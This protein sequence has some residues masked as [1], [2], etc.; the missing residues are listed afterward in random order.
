MKRDLML[1]AIIAAMSKEEKKNGTNYAAR[2]CD[3]SNDHSNAKAD[4]ENDV[5]VHQHI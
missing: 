3:D 2:Q 5:R 1:L 4:R